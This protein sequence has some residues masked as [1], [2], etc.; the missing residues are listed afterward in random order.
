[1]TKLLLLR[2]CVSGV[3]FMLMYYLAKLYVCCYCISLYVIVSL[4]VLLVC[5]C[6]VC[7]GVL[8]FFP[9]FC[10]LVFVKWQGVRSVCETVFSS[11]WRSLGM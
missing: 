3:M 5:A 8:Y 4:Y 6:L 9:M 10:M 7:Q 11:C 2:L 1:M